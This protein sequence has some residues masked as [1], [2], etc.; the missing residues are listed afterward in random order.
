LEEFPQWGISGLKGQW[1][2]DWQ[3]QH[4]STDPFSRFRWSNYNHCPAKTKYQ[5]RDDT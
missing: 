5:Q 3:T 4:W 1:A 2:S